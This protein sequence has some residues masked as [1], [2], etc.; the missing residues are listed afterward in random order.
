MID[1]KTAVVMTMTGLHPEVTW[2]PCETTSMAKRHQGDCCFGISHCSITIATPKTIGQSIFCTRFSNKA[3]LSHITTC[4]NQAVI[5]KNPIDL[6]S[7]GCLSIR[8]LGGAPITS[9]RTSLR[10][11]PSGTALRR[12]PDHCPWAAKPQLCHAGKNIWK[13]GDRMGIA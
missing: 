6:P 2:P 1:M 13:N 12:R 5:K 11:S 9:W 4:P 7:R 3:V 10:I 8:L